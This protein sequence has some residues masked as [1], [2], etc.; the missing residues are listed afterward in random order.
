MI[1]SLVLLI[2]LICPLI[3]IF[4][5]WDHTIQTG[6]D[7][8]YA[9][10]ILALCVGAAH[11]FARLILTLVQPRLAAKRVLPRGAHHLLS[12]GFFTSLFSDAIS[13]PAF[14]LRI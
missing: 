3:E 8:E 1:V 14:T 10:V 13:P 6:N 11:S 12:F 4:D 2:C 9:L 5:S 7:T